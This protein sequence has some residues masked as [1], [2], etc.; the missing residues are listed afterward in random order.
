MYYAEKEQLMR[1]EQ[2]VKLTMEHLTI[3]LNENSQPVA[4]TFPYSLRLM[5]HLAMTC[6][7]EGSEQNRKIADSILKNWL[8][9]QGFCH[10]SPFL[11]MEIFFRYCDRLSEEVK[12]NMDLY[13]ERWIDA[14]TEPELEVIGCNDNYPLMAAA[15]LLG[16]ALRYKRFDLLQAVQLRMDQLEKLLKRRGF[17]SEYTSNTYTPI[18]ALCL[19]EIAEFAMHPQLFG[20]DSDSYSDEEKTVLKRI[21]KQA[22]DAEARV[23]MDLLM[24][25]H[26]ETAQLGGACSRGYARDTAA[27]F[28][29][30]RFVYY[31]LYGDEL[32][33]NPVPAVMESD[34]DFYGRITHKDDDFLRL[35]FA[36]HAMVLYHCP[37]ELAEWAKNKTYPYTIIG[38]AESVSGRDNPPVSCA[39]APSSLM[40]AY[41]EYPEHVN[42]LTTYMTKT[43]CLGTARYGWL[44]GLQSH[45]L[46]LL[47]KKAL[48]EYTQNSE[49]SYGEAY[50]KNIGQRQV[51]ALFTRYVIND[52][53]IFGDD[54]YQNWELGICVTMQKENTAIALYSP[55]M[56]YD[57]DITSLKL[58][59]NI[60][61]LFGDGVDE[62]CIGNRTLP[63]LVG[64]STLDECVYVN[65]GMIFVCLK[66]L[67]Q[68]HVDRTV[69]C[70]VKKVNKMIEIAFYNYKGEK[71]N[72]DRMELGTIANGVAVEVRQS[73]EYADFDA[74]C[75]TMKPRVTDEAFTYFGRGVR[76]FFYEN[77]GRTMECE[78]S[79][80]SLQMRYAMADGEVI[81]EPKLTMDTACIKLD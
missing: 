35:M 2:I 5:L 8:P 16:G 42:L 19:S 14:L 21:S 65:C 11:C 77:D 22:L 73:S 20:T 9:N 57:R 80:L 75:Q 45:N 69:R 55:R 6:L 46:Q 78:Y 37:C 64:A 51:G 54:G 27:S 70:T 74:F 62:I 43:Y 58:T 41:W 48:S 53:E 68:R 49:K 23:H 47:Y 40:P 13:C 7:E 50:A 34:A 29:H 36:W 63:N 66:P 3:E 60:T 26:W 39:P 30:A 56:L 44:G 24:H 18:Q 17:T 28:S 81:E 4:G 61:D 72:F 76:K 10:F 32:T 79:P 38:T 33:V 71:R 12:R 67:M 1:R 31:M 59:V 15:A 52:H 25:M